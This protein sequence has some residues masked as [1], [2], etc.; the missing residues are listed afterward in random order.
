MGAGS[1]IVKGMLTILG[2]MAIT[3]FIIV[4]GGAVGASIA[5]LYTFV[6]FSVDV[7]LVA[8]IGSLIALVSGET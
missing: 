2:S 3:L 6:G 4:L 7:V 8:A 1:N 5:L